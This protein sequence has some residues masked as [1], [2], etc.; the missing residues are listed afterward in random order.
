MLELFT[1]QGCSA[2][3]PADRLL[4][5]LAGREGVIALSFHVPY[6]DHMG[7][8]DP[9]ALAVSVQR[10]RGYARALKQRA[11]YTPQLVVQGA[12]EAV[13]HDRE[14]VERLIAAA[15]V[16]AT[17]AA[18]VRGQRPPVL[19][20]TIPALSLPQGEAQLWL[21][22][23]SRSEI[24]HVANGENAGHT[25]HHTHV[26]RWAAPVATIEEVP[27]VLSIAA[28]DAQSADGVAV[29]LQRARQGPVLAAGRVDLR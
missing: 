22:A 29:L 7:W 3:P 14:A 17:I 26:V 2:C 1:S 12:A 24:V 9:F 8:R 13:G 27:A 4:A 20:L 19:S 11:I 21:V 16:I 15:P 5:S 10:Q 18:S 23:Y 28:P 6:W 25:L